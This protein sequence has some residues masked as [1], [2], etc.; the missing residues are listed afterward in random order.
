MGKKERGLNLNDLMDSLGNASPGSPGRPPLE[1]EYERR[2]FIWQRVA[3]VIAAFGIVI[4]TAGVIV[5]ALHLA[6]VK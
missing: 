2:K 6:L 3:V 4:A 1:A 5:G